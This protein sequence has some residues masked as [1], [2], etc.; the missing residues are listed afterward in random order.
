MRCRGGGG[1]WG[2][3]RNRSRLQE[4]ELPGGING[5]LNVLRRRIMRLDARSQ[6]HQGADLVIGETGCIAPVEAF[7]P[8]RAAARASLNDHTL[9]AETTFNDLE[10]LGRY[11]EVIGIG[12]TGDN[13]LAQ[14]WIG[15]DDGLMTP[16]GERIGSEENT[17]NRSFN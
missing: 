8:H 15:I 9:I 6:C 11:D 4:P 16:A 5:P 3:G 10:G 13:R 7:S 12:R 14:S 17:R 2:E 1:Q